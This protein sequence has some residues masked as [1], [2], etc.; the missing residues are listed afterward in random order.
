MLMARLPSWL[1]HTLL[2]FLVIYAGWAGGQWTW[3]LL[4]SEP[5]VAGPQSVAPES[6]TGGY[7]GSLANMTLFGVPDRGNQPRVSEV[8][9]QTARETSL[10][11][12][13]HGVTLSTDERLSGAIVAR[14]GSDAAYYKVDDVLPGQA[15]LLAVEP[16]RILLQRNGE[17]ESLS[18][19]D[20]GLQ[21]GVASAASPSASA[22]SMPGDSAA[23]LD[24][25]RSQL[26]EDPEA[27]LAGIG[28]RDAG[29][30]VAGYVYDGSNPMLSQM[31]L[32]PGDRIIAI[33]GHQLGEMSRDRELMEQWTTAG[34][35]QVEIARG[36]TTFSF[37]VP[38]PD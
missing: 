24:M 38:V 13:L 7:R 31:N 18:F 35:L 3:R 36:G 27:A 8:A 10:R 5:A 17:V 23:F 33:N 16:G 19:E 4:W 9:R 37:S 6:A 28:L 20:D 12:T 1:A 21:L 25:A 11:L 32:Q 22:A 2:F 14:D 29:D 34:T 15:K 30:N 26:E